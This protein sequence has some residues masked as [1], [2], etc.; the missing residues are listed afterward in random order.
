MAGIRRSPSAHGASATRVGT[1]PI[2]ASA[3]VDQLRACRN[4]C[5]RGA[6]D[7][8]SREVVGVVDRLAVRTHRQSAVISRLLPMQRRSGPMVAACVRVEEAGAF[9]Q[10]DNVDVYLVPRSI[11][12]DG[13]PELPSLTAEQRG[14]AKRPRRSAGCSTT[15]G[16]PAAASVKFA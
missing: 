4:W 16:Q 1:P 5:S 9:Q 6:L 10:I 2:S 12:Y 3:D 15:H 14:A 11:V 7:L 8:M 13:L